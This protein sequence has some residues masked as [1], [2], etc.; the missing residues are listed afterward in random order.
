MIRSPGLCNFYGFL[1]L[2]FRMRAEIIEK[3]SKMFRNLKCMPTL[4]CI[5]VASYLLRPAIDVSTR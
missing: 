3:L 4:H 5:A 2:V 1:L